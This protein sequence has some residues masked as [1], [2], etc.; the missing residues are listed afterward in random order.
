MVNFLLITHTIKRVSAGQE[1]MVIK[2]VNKGVATRFSFGTNKCSMSI[3][4]PNCT[5]LL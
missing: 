4:V 3:M 5:V 2:L 1:F